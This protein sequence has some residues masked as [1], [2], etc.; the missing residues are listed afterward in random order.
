MSRRKLVFNRN[1]RIGVG[2]RDRLLREDRIKVRERVRLHLKRRV[3]KKLIK[4]STVPGTRDV[5]PRHIK[6]AKTRIFAMKTSGNQCTAVQE[7]NIL[8]PSTR[9]AGTKSKYRSLTN[10]NAKSKILLEIKNG[11]KQTPPQ[12]KHG[13]AQLPTSDEEDKKPTKI[14]TKKIKNTTL[15]PYSG[16]CM[17]QNPRNICLFSERTY[18]ISISVRLSS[19]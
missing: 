11:D 6:M 16:T 1:R 9:R 18:R 8:P 3:Q 2:I 13:R 19:H 7:V 5:D 4:E 15:E 10:K 12:D 14:K 17:F